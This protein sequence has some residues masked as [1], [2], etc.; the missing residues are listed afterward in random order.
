MQEELDPQ[1]AS[2]EEQANESGQDEQVVSPDAA[3]DQG[4]AERERLAKLEQSYKEAHRTITKLTQK[5]SDYEK[6][7]QPAE[8]EIPADAWFTDPARSTKKVVADVLMEFESRQE[9]KHQTERLLQDFAEE[10]GL[11]RRQL[12]ALNE[13]IQAAMADPN[14]YL[15]MLGQLHA[16]RN[17]GA[18]IQKVARLAKDSVERNA[19]AVT[20][21]TTAS[22]VSPPGKPFSEMSGNEMRDWILRNH[23]EASDD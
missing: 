18:E 7:G 3:P 16:A 17:T 19:R 2:D 10:R 9:Q 12:Q 11:S 14:A 23:G 5:L 4:Q 13:D 22:R 8:A 15:E 1:A 20:T 6:R 21:E